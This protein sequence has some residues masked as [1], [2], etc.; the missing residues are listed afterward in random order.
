MNISESH[1]QSLGR[2]SPDGAHLAGVSQNRVLVREAESLK[3]VAVHVCADK[4]ERVDW[5]P[6]SKYLF[7]QTV[8]QG[9]VQVWSVGDAEWACRIDVG[10][11]GV[12]RAHW[13]PDSRHLLIVSDFQLFLSI[14]RLED[15]SSP[16]QIRYPKYANRGIS[17]SRNGRWLAVLRRTDCRDSVALHSCEENWALITEFSVEA[18]CADLAWAPGDASLMLWERP[19]RAARLLRYSPRGERLSCLSVDDCGPL[20]CNFPSPSG[21]FHAV[22]GIDGHVRVIGSDSAKL[23]PL[24]KL[25]HDIKVATA[26][27]GEANIDVLR[28]ELVGA[29]PVARHLHRVGALPQPSSTLSVEGGSVRYLRLAKPSAARVPEERSLPESE[30]AVDADGV[31][32]RGIGQ[33]MWSP[34][35]RYLATRVYSQP[36]TVWIWD[37]GCLQLSAVLIHRS[38]VRSISWEPSSVACGDH[39]RLAISTAD[40]CLF[41]WSPRGA[42]VAPCSLSAARLTWRVD[43]G[44]LLLQ[45]RDRACVCV[46]PAFTASRPPPANIGQ[47]PMEVGS[48]VDEVQPQDGGA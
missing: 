15:H 28:E 4:V 12:A 47:S 22:G 14:W 37:L 44:A 39:S 5:S 42:T 38:P 46:P 36:S 13:S 43:G 32:K 41:L 10:L 27:V 30:L 40:P 11:G 24:V 2:W 17:F 45:E 20:R 9:V 25:T 33:A 8:A 21:Q 16:V 31:P 3:L 6:D 29:G 1:R 18:D 26:E 48:I 34:D 19:A 7:S 35:E 23:W